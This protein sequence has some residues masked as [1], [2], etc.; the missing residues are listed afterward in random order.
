MEPCYRVSQPTD[1]EEDGDEPDE[2]EEDEGLS[3]NDT[4]SPTD[5]GSGIDTPATSQASADT[6]PVKKSGP[7]AYRCARLRFC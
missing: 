2:A 4:D 7:G 6:K 3:P 5:H 1:D